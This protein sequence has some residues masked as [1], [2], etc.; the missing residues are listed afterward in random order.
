[1]CKRR[2]QQERRE[3]VRRIPLVLVACYE[4]GAMC[5]EAKE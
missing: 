4:R 3:T 1:M 5:E 2:E